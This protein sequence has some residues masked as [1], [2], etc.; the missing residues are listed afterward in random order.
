MTGVSKGVDVIDDPFLHLNGSFYRYETHLV[1][2]YPVELTYYHVVAFKICEYGGLPSDVG[3][4]IVG[5][6]TFRNPYGYLPG[7]LFGYL[8]FEVRL[9]INMLLLCISNTVTIIM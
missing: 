5:D 7:E 4:M 8:P 2:K 1:Y 9:D 6:V 3:A